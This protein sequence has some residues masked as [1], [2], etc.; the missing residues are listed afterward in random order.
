[1]LDKSWTLF[2]VFSSTETEEKRTFCCAGHFHNPELQ[3]SAARSG[4]QQ[5]D[6]FRCHVSVCEKVPGSCAGGLLFLSR[7]RENPLFI[8]Y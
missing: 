3:L 5:G 4:V 2:S 1:M 6:A 7:L 8:F